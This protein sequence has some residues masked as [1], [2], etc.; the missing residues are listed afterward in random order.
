MGDEEVESR[1]VNNAF[2]KLIKNKMEIIKGLET[3]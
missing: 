2:K 3:P 1:N